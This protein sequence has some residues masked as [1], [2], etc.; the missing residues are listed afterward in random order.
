MKK[1]NKRKTEKL[2]KNNNIGWGEIVWSQW[3][4]KICIGST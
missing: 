4:D 3:S 1:K 2:K